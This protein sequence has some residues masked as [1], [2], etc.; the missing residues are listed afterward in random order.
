M[1]FSSSEGP[2]AYRSAVDDDGAVD[3]DA[4]VVAREERDDDAVEGANASEVLHAV[5][6]SSSAAAE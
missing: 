5:A 2:L 3:G 4:V 6:S 1:S